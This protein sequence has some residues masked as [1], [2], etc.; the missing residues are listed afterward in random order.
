MAEVGGAGD[1]TGTSTWT[2]GIALGNAFLADRP[3]T[4]EAFSIYLGVSASCD[5]DAAVFSSGLFKTGTW[6]LEWTESDI[7]FTSGTGWIESGPVGLL[8]VPGEHYAAVLGL[9]CAGSTTTIHYQLPVGGT[10]GAGDI[11]GTAQNLTYAA[12]WSTDAVFTHQAI[13]T[14]AQRFYVTDL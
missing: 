2:S 14:L 9:R 4:L 1:E 5:I 8:L 7:P 10:T 13:A 6:E 3:A 12:A 11:V